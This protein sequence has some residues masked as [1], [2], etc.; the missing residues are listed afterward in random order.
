MREEEA[1]RIIETRLSEG[2]SLALAGQGDFRGIKQLLEQCLNADI[3]AVL[4]PARVKG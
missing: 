4:G 2:K 3:P 1:K